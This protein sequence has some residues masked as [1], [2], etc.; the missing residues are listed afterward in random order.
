MVVNK[1]RQIGRDKTQLE[2]PHAATGCCL[3]T[4]GQTLTPAGRLSGQAPSPAPGACG[5]PKAGT[6]RLELPAQAGAL[7]TAPRSRNKAEGWRETS[8]PTWATSGAVAL[9]SHSLSF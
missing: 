1:S 2:E 6:T 9:P 8:V 7:G 4:C 5:L 3:L